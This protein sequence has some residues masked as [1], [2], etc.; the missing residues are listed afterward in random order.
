MGD[1]TKP[2]EG[3]SDSAPR[4]TWLAA[5]RTY[6]AWLRTGLGTLG[7][8]LAVGRL[9]PALIDAEH[10]A[11]GLLGVGYGALGVFLLLMSAY[12]A[13]RV[14]AALAA[15]RPLPTDAWSIWVLTAASLALAAGTI[16]LV[17]VAI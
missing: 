2:D 15:Q 7:I 4:R 16:V 3:L 11:F 1:Q 6:L 10:V 12:R 8:A 13:Q 9:L 5:E 17:V 14:R